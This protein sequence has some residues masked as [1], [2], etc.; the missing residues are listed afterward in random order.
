[1]T[2]P[3]D[4]P[5]RAAKAMLEG[6]YAEAATLIASLESHAD[7]HAALDEVH[8]L[9]ERVAIDQSVDGRIDVDKAARGI[10]DIRSK[11][12]ASRPATVASGDDVGGR[13]LR[14]LLRVGALAALVAASWWVWSRG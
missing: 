8:A 4:L 12:R 6:R 9:M 11:L 5:K 3:E 10:E 14:T 13:T 1:M 2:V 7:Q